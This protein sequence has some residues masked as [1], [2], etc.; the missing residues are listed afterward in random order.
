MKTVFLSLSLHLIS[1]VGFNSIARCESKETECDG[2]II[3]IAIT[4][5]NCNARKN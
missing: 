2:I 1:L 4:E 5:P 3:N